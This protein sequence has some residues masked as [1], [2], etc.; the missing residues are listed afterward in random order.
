V[1]V[2]E[3]AN[4]ASRLSLGGARTFHNLTMV[5]LLDPSSGPAGYLTLDDALAADTIEI[6]EVSERGRVPELRLQSRSDRPVFLLDGEELVGAKQNRILNLSILVPGRAAIEIPVSCVEQGRWSWRSKGFQGADRLIFSKLRRSNAE[7]VSLNMASSGHPHGDQHEVWHHIAEKSARMSVHSDTSAAGAMYERYA[8]DLDEFVSNIRPAPGQ[9][10]AA[11]L[12]NGRFAGLD[13]LAGPDLL[14]RL[15]PKLVRSY[16]L[17]AMEEAGPVAPRSGLA[18]E[19]HRD[20][21][22]TV[23]SIG[24]MTAERRG[25]VGLGEGVRL[26]GEGLV[27]GALIAGGTMVHLGIWAASYR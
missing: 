18:P 8:P 17:D 20:V 4:L 22:A 27:G 10:G 7:A 3:L 26:T 25:S 6:V 2:F 21:E 15:L 23:A 14:T 13:L 24:R 5:P 9:V 11:F 16:A 1:S 19:A 12:L